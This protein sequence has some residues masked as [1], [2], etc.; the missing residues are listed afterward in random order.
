MK[1]FLCVLFAVVMLF[2]LVAC[3]KN[4]ADDQND[5]TPEN[6][7]NDT[8]AQE[9]DLTPPKKL[10]IGTS[11]LLGRF[12]AG[13]SPSEDLIGCDA[14]FDTVFRWDPYEKKAFSNILESWEWED[15]TTF[16]AHMRDDVYFSNGEN[17]T[18]EV[19]VF[20]Y[21]S[22]IERGSNY[23]NPAKLVVD[24]CYAR[25]K[26]TAQFKMEEPY[27]GFPYLR[28]YLIDKS[29]SQG[30]AEGWD[31]QEWYRP[32][33]S[34]P[35]R[36][37]EWV[38]DSHML[39]KSRGDEYWYKDEGPIVID[40]I[41]I[42]MYPDAS[43]L[44][45]ALET[46]EIDV[47]ASVAS[48]DYER[49]LD[50]GGNGYDITTNVTGS[51]MYFCFNFKSTDKWD[52][53]RVREAVALGVK[54]DEIGRAAYGPFYN[55]AKSVASVMCPDYIEVGTYEYNPERAK[56]L[57]AE[58]GYGPNNPLKIETTLMQGPFYENSFEVFQFY[59]NQLGIEATCEFVDAS[60]GIA[61]WIS[62]TGCEYGFWSM[63]GGSPGGQLNWTLGWVDDQTGVF[64]THITDPKF[65]ELYKTVKSSTDENERSK[66]AK[67][68]QQY[69]HDGFW[70]I[71]IS[72]ETVAFGYRTDKIKREQLERI[73]IA[74]NHLQVSRLAL[75]SFWK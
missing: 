64:F 16:V 18:A 59:A 66:A 22:H 12:L 14:V 36:V 52:D 25:D 10:T 19:L 70:R 49:F 55:Q 28:V 21:L 3:G 39:L 45:M 17:A 60:T 51:L 4:A 53:I 5:N 11:G 13:L 65:L 57:L 31:S 33:G 73:A 2:A 34:G 41:L 72:E 63:Y 15:D 47:A 27:P 62:P 68:L 35:Y 74:P 30:L 44:F 37:E 20:S 1:K 26:Y 9:D 40:E 56:Q 38:S 23:V 71:P 7:P 69:A 50:V 46:G 32:V 61:A 48:S 8:P 54:W 58:A 42:K 24:E 67:E 43:T 75:E 6:G 29:W